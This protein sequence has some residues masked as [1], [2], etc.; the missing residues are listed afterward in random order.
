MKQLSGKPFD[1]WA[2]FAEVMLEAA[3]IDSSAG[4]A[5]VVPFVTASYSRRFDTEEGPRQRVVGVFEEARAREL[6]DFDHLVCLLARSEVSPGSIEDM[7]VRWEVARQ[8]AREF[9]EQ[10]RS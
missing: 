4:L 6:F 3:E 9:V 7:Q 5:Q 2:T 10:S 8:K 1:G